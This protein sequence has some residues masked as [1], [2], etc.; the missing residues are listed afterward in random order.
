MGRHWRTFSFWVTW[1][2]GSSAVVRGMLYMML[3]GECRSS[4][5][6]WT[7]EGKQEGGQELPW[8]AYPLCVMMTQVTSGSVWLADSAFLRCRRVLGF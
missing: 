5:E 4:L 6:R 7:R 3:S 1:G 2:L 8:L